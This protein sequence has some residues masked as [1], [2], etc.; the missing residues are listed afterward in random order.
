M[1][2]SGLVI[3]WIFSFKED[4]FILGNF[5]VRSVGDLWAGFI[6]LWACIEV[7]WLF[8]EQGL[9]SII[10]SNIGFDF[11]REFEEGI[12]WVFGGVSL[13]ENCALYFG[14]IFVAH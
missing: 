13:W 14:S 10:V 4:A 6:L 7:Y 1:L 8:F 2:S 11:G 5:R 3:W 12:S 9:S